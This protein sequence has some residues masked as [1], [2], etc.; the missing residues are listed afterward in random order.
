MEMQEY[1]DIIRRLVM[2]AAHQD[3]INERQ[4]IINSKQDI[5]NARLTTAIERLEGILV[6]IRDI[7]NRGNGR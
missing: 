1:D 3:V 4:D 5:T 2:I 7:L 6:A